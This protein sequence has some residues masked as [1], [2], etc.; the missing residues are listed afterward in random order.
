[1]CADSSDEEYIN[2]LFAGLKC[3]I[4]LTDPPYFLPAE[5]YKTRKTF[6]RNL[7]D[8]GVLESFFKHF[9]KDADKILKDDGFLFMFCDG[10]SYPLFYYHAYLFFKSLRP[11]IWN[12]KVSFNGYWF[13]HQHELILFGTRYNAPLMPTGYGDILSFS[14]VKVDEREHAA[15][16]PVDL[17]QY[18]IR[19]VSK[20]HTP[21]TIV[22]DPFC[23]SGSTLL[24]CES[25][26]KI[27]YGCDMN[28]DYVNIAVKRWEAATGQKAQKLAVH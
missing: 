8:L 15:Q 13:R 11:L 7:A 24:A 19:A 5:H 2:E 3:D 22:Y 16:K 17:L 12:K 1:M 10:Q 14:A 6:H 21:D 25:T 4:V 20:M 18:L 9:F 26:N 23:G 28:F 27:F